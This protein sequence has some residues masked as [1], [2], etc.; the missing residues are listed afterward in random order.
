MVLIFLFSQQDGENSSKTSGLFLEL[1]AWLNIDRAIIEAYNLKF[2]VRKLAHMTEYFILYLL[3][4]RLCK[5]YFSWPQALWITWLLTVGYA[6]TD[7][8]HQ[9]FIEGRTGTIVDVGIDG[10]GAA[11]ALLLT[12]IRGRFGGSTIA[13]KT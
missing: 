6:G 9:T 5:H 13:K 7:E 1:M 2:Y 4:F 10:L 8:F 3:L 11:L 12:W